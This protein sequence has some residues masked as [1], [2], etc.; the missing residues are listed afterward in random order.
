MTSLRFCSKELEPLGIIS[1]VI[2]VDMQGVV[3]IILYL[4]HKFI[5]FVSLPLPKHPYSACLG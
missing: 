2:A 5:P 3:A 4:R 1:R